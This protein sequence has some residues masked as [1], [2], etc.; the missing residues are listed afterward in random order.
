[1]DKKRGRVADRP[2]GGSRIENLDLAVGGKQH[3]PAEARDQRG[4]TGQEKAR[5]QGHE[6]RLAAPRRAAEK[7]VRDGAAAGEA[8]AAARAEEE[9]EPL[10][11]SGL[12][13]R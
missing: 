2:G 7:A 8:A 11:A 9:R 6:A 5:G 3:Y 10:L 12:A 4:H 13:V 1:V